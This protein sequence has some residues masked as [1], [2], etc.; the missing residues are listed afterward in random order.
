MLQTEQLIRKAESLPAAL[1]EEA[2]HYID[3]LSQKAYKSYAAEKLSEAEREMAK[4]DAKW[5]TEK[6]FWDEED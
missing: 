1:F 6:E 5:L 2:A 3:Y 4:P